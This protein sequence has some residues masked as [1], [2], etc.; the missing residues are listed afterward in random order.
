M[1]PQLQFMQLQFTIERLITDYVHCIDDDR[2]E[3][4][5]GFF[6]DPSV[7]KIT[8]DENYERALPI[9]VFFPNSRGMLEDHLTPLRKGNIYHPPHYRHLPPSTPLFP[10]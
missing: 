8:S 2:L 7:Y 6:A 3:E 5:P 9:A 10:H 4:W 1:D